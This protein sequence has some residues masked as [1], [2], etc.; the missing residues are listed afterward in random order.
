MPERK[1]Y[2]YKES[3]RVRVAVYCRVS[4]AEEAQVGSPEM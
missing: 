1:E 2:V 4:T 3:S